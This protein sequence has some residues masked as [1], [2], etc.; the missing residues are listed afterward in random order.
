M[1]SLERLLKDEAATDR[2]GRRSRI[3]A[4]GRR[5]RRS[6]GRT[7]AREN[8]PLAR[9]SSGHGDDETLEVPVPPS[10]WSKLRPQDPGRSFRSL[11]LADASSLTSSFPTR[12]SPT[13]SVRGMPE[14]AE[15]ALP[16]DRITL[17]FSHED[18]GRRI[19]LDGSGRGFRTDQ[20]LACHS[21]VPARCSL[22]WRPSAT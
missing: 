20:P 6:L 13:A 17:T 19:H 1:K 9:P 4:E 11:R 5:M 15:E 14:K 12:R 18:E 22:S 3:G 8:R 16:A 10:P 2:I 7:S 21:Q